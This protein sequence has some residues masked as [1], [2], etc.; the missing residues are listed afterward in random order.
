MTIENFK[1]VSITI[2]IEQLLP[3]KA[4]LLSSTPTANLEGKT[5]SWKA[6]VDANGSFVITYTYEVVRY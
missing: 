1:N 3:Y 6:D 5:L 4:N 2:K